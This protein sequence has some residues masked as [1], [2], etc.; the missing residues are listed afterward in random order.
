MKGFTLVEVLVALGMVAVALAAGL[1][2]NAS[3]ASRAQRAPELLLAEVCARNRFAALRLSRQWPAP[4]EDISAC[5]QADRQLEV[6]TRVSDAPGS[7][8][9]QVQVSVRPVGHSDAV[10]LSLATVMGRY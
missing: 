5:A 3:L 4:G 10:L 9:R 6:L 1:S 7:G 2:L 8:L